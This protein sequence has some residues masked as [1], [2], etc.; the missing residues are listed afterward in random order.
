MSL[1]QALRQIEKQFGANK[2]MP[3]SKAVGA[4]IQRVPTGSLSLD[5]ESGGGWI[6]GKVNEVFG[7]YSG[8]KTF[9]ALST[10]AT[11][12]KKYPEANFAWMD[13]E[14]AFDKEWAETIGVDLDRLLIFTPEYME[15][16]LDIAD[17]LIK[18]EDIFLL[19]IDSWAAL[20]PKTE[21][22]GTME[23]QT[24]GLRARV[25]NKFIRKA[26]PSSNLAQEGIDLGKTT[27]LVINQVYS[28]IGPY[29]GEETPG[30]RQL[31]FLA[32]LRIRIRRSDLVQ[33][34]NGTVICQ[35]SSFVI[36][37]NKTHPPKTKGEFWFSLTDNVM[38]KAGSISRLDE[39]VRYG[40]AYGVIKQ[41]GSW[42][43]L[44]PHIHEEKFQG[45]A[46]LVAWISEQ[47]EE[48]LSSLETL[49]LGAIHNV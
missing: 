38:G 28:G 18:S 13:A 31:G 24:M 45:R 43:T 3:A 29:A 42:L 30:G 6:Q 48:T 14:G 9:I 33:D 5:I 10:V 4:F 7:P 12:Q 11:N 23:D 17:A 46:N 26:R 47:E 27:L 25:G 8:G 36:E 39:L 35:Q 34:P 41:A 32:M 16:A 20:S 37:K 1:A 21:F 19:V 22:D 15:E 44:P 49:V 2:V 40:I